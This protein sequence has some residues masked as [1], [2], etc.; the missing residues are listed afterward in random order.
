[1][2]PLDAPRPSPFLHDAVMLD[3]IKRSVK[4]TLRDGLVPG[5]GLR[6]WAP[7]CAV[8][9]NAHAV[10]IDVLEALGPRWRDV[11]VRVFSTDADPD[12]LARARAGFYSPAAVRGLSAAKLERYFVKSSEGYRV[13]AFV[14]EACLFVAH[15]LKEPAP[16]T[17]LDLIVCGETIASRPASAR[18]GALRSFHG[19]LAPNGLLVDR[20]GHASSM[21]ELFAPTPRRRGS[22]AA[23]AVP[24]ARVTAAPRLLAESDDRFLALF[25]QTEDA[26]L[27]RDVVTDAILEA[28]PAARR[29][30]GLTLAEFRETRGA[31]LVAPAGA[32]RRPEGER[33][34]AERLSLPHHRRKDGTLFA[35]DCKTTFFMIKGRPSDVWTVR[36]AAARL[37]AK[38]GE[39]RAEAEEAFVGEVVHELRSPLTIIQ[40]FAEILSGGVPKR[41][42]RAEFFGRIQSQTGRMGHLID[43]L[44]DL[45]AAHGP[46]GA[47]RAEALPLAPALWEVIAAFAAIAKRRGIVITLDIPEGLAIEAVRADLPH[48]FGNLLDNALKF[49]R[50]GGRVDVRARVE[51][52]MAIISVQDTGLGIPPSDLSRVFE[53]FYR[54]ERTRGVKGTGLG[55]AIVRK[56]VEGNGGRI[57]AESAPGT[58]TVFHVALKLAAPRD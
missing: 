22:Y 10:A 52:G 44:L 37:R 20:T 27:I 25:S 46:K 33:R 42:E 32:A 24:G 19:A 13:R 29:L 58:G 5:K 23:W 17:Q 15:E 9:E 18:K 39:R 55:L 6:V 57:W 3:A 40:C 51:D 56:I 34:S 38:S 12:S 43:R 35:A 2:T 45:S 1:M 8:G 30:Y 49:N 54:S 50:R 41:K 14:K 7:Q 21:P 48:I 26:M 28:N 16:F 47:A 53:R 4:R 36:D 31:D 11:S